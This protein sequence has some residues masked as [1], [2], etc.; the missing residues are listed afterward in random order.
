VMGA[1]H[2]ALEDYGTLV[3]LQHLRAYVPA[4]D[5]DVATLAS[6][7]FTVAHPAYLRLGL[8]EEPKDVAVPPFAAWRKLTCGGGWVVVVTGSLAGGLW[9]AVRELEPARRPALWLLSELPAGELPVE[10]RADLAR[11]R[12]LLV[13]EEHVA[14]GGVGQSLAA[15]LL[16]SGSVPEQFATRCAR[17][18]VSGRYGS[19][20]F[21][22]R[23]SGLDPASIVEF[24]AVQDAS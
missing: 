12:R 21:H 23:E 13:V 11:S 15:L 8:A 1:T 19:Q 18:Y 14:Q 9:G 4:F 20:K 24:L 10:F 6:T 3:S 2:H 16:S 5:A 17:G 22:R 7:L